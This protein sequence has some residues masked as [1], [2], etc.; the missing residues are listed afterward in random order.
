MSFLMGKQKGQRM[1]NAFS[2]RQIKMVEKD[3]NVFR[4]FI[5]MHVLEV[6][7]EN[8]LIIYTIQNTK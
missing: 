8:K 4:K 2:S 6:D 5:Y 1:P 7:V 3:Q